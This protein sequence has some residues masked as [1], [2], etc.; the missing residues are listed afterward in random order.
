MHA[1]VREGREEGRLSV[2]TVGTMGPSAVP[3]AVVLDALHMRHTLRACAVH[4]GNM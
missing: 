1:H 2:D 3:R 4:D